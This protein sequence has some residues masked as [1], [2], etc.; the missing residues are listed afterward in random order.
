MHHGRV[1]ERWGFFTTGR[2]GERSWFGGGT[3]GELSLTRDSGGPFRTQDGP[4]GADRSWL[5]E[6]FGISDE[7]IDD[8]LAWWTEFQRRPVP[9]PHEWDYEHRRRE[10]LLWKRLRGAVPRGVFVRPA[11]FVPEPVVIRMFVDDTSGIALWPGSVGWPP[12]PSFDE[13]SLAMSAST[14][15]R[16]HA[17]V[18]EYTESISGPRERIDEQWRVD[19][20]RRGYVLSQELQAEL[21]EAYLVQYEPHT[22]AGPDAG[23]PRRVALG[24]V[25]AQDLESLPSLP[26]ALGD[27][28]SK[29]LAQRSRFDHASDET[30]TAHHAWEDEGMNLRADLQRHWGPTYTVRP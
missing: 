9:T 4:C 6:K 24:Q 7:L 13:E 27:R 30:A 29:W 25:T 26:A 19:H 18:E 20:D 11:D 5:G 28:L 16:L 12:R 1:G 2:D 17:W 21:G 8:A 14:R 10:S 15:A 23:L 22:S 3:G